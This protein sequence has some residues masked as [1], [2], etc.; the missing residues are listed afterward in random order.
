[1]KVTMKK[2]VVEDAKI[3]AGLAIQM[4]KS[5]TMDELAEEFCEYIEGESSAVFLSMVDGKV[6]GF[7]QCGLRHDYVEG[8]NTSPVGY[9]EGIFVTEGYRNKGVAKDMLEAC[10]VWAKAQGC[11]EFASDCELDNTVSRE[12]HLKVG[13]EEANRIICFKKRLVDSLD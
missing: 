5:H 13:F 1:M 11:T 7:A 3:V 10:Q 12:F 9:L 6:I 2:A 8:T 4:W